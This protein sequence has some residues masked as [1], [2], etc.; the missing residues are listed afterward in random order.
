ME[1]LYWQPEKGI[2]AGTTL[3]LGGRSQGP[4]AENNLALNVGDD[5]ADVLYN[6]RLLAKDLHT[7]LSHMV[8]PDQTHSTSFQKV[9]LSEGGRGMY[10]RADALAN[11]DALYTRDENLFLL[12]YHADCIPVLLYDPKTRLIA[13]IHA[14]WRGNVNGIIMKVLKHLTAAENIDVAATY[15]YIGPSLG[16]ESFEA[17]DDII[18]LVKQ[19]P[20]DTADCYHMDA[21]GIYHLDAKKLAFRQLETCGI[22]PAKITV[23]PEDTYQDDRFY[24]YRKDHQTGR[25]VSF[26]AMLSSLPESS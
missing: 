9:T 14:G 26:I 21:P 5:E 22:D 18:D 7:D 23:R 19:M 8:S 25:H 6:R 15:A 2:L 17:R 3:R 13:A 10:T 20:V 24:S 4:K 16:K 12:T 1:Y 11:T